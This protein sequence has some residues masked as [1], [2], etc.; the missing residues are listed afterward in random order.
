M[1]TLDI[2]DTFIRALLKAQ[3]AEQTYRTNDDDRYDPCGETKRRV[4]EEYIAAIHGLAIAVKDLAE[5][6]RE[7]CL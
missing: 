7:L 6:G 3:Q 2:G 5:L 1:S 4:R